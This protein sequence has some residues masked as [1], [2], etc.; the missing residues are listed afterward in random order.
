MEFGGCGARSFC[1]P[2][3]FRRSG[4]FFA[5]QTVPQIASTTNASAGRMAA[6]TPRQAS[7]H[8][9]QPLTQWYA[10]CVMVQRTV[11]RPLHTLWVHVRWFAVTGSG[12]RRASCTE[13]ARTRARARARGAASEH[14]A[15]YMYPLYTMYGV[16]E[17]AAAE[18][19][20]E[21]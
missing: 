17:S 12:S 15:Y 16:G 14:H 20:A 9:E 13:S 4:C 19:W 5:S 8:F 3:C 21:C 2:L 18:S 1:K 7:S 10:R 6:P 11:R